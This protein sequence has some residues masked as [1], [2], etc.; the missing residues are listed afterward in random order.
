MASWVHVACL[1][2]GKQWPGEAS[3]QLDAVTG[4]LPARVVVR[5]FGP[6]GDEPAVLDAVGAIRDTGA[7]VLLLAAMHGGSARLLTLAARQSGL[8][9]VI[10]CHDQKHS[11][12]SS[13]LAAEALRRLRH[14]VELIH[15]AGRGAA[16]MLASAGAAGA[17]IRRLASARIG[18]LGPLHFNLIGASVDP[19]VVHDR[20]GPW[21]VP[22]ALRE[23]RESVARIES[24]RID[25]TINELNDL[26]S[27]NVPGKTL[28]KATA[29][30][31]ALADLAAAQRLDALA[32]DCW[33][34]TVPQFGTSPCLGFALGD[35]TI[36]CEGD[37]VLALTLLAGRAIAGSPG[38]VGDLYSFCE[39][40]G[41]AALMH[42][43]GCAGLHAGPEP[44]TIGTQPPP[45]PVGASA[46][47]VACQ[48]ELP[49]G[50]GTIVLL[51]GERLDRL[52]LRPCEI[53]GTEF[54][55]QM[56][57]KVRVGGDRAEFVRRAAGNHYIV[58]PGD[59]RQA[60]RLWAGWSGVEIN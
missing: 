41:L 39:D 12:A 35:C 51:H 21:V 52:H 50:A 34:E 11:L 37:T 20:F 42:C 8:P 14:R 56:V 53:V 38:Y 2:V 60:W 26:Y 49:P 33:T 59:T 58:F 17:A 24:G 45:C 55:E 27:V 9:T 5:A 25:D 29:L 28:R 4:A 13:A 36:A 3:G 16:E 32:I 43:A 46:A 54:P 10:W 15:G 19:L 44:M 40:T 1:A 22:L 57:V 30:H 18:Q 7:D 47:V 48:P 6:A 31:L 23:L